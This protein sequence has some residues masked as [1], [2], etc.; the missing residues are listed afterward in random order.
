TI[1][2]PHRALRPRV[3]QPSL[4]SIQ[5]G[6]DLG[7]L[8]LET[9]DLH[10]ARL[11]YRIGDRW[12]RRKDLC[13]SGSTDG[14]EL[15]FQ[16]HRVREALHLE[17]CKLLLKCGNRRR[18]RGNTLGE[19]VGIVHD[20]IAASGRQDRACERDYVN[21]D[22]RHEWSV[23]TGNWPLLRTSDATGIVMRKVAP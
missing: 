11:R 16:P 8:V 9:R 12:W 22:F 6:A 7:Q 19:D 3:R 23:W 1:G 4:D 13:C 5:L 10:C 17:R 21:P 2:R 14:A 20:T 15:T 18:V